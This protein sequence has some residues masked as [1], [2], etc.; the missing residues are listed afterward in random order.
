ELAAGGADVHSPRGEKDGR[1]N[2]APGESPH[3]EP[4]SELLRL[5]DGKE[6]ENRLE[7]P[8]AVL[9][10]LPRGRRPSECSERGRRKPPGDPPDLVEERAGNGADGAR[11]EE[12]GAQPDSRLDGE[13]CGERQG[14]QVWNRRRCAAESPDPAPPPP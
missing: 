2:P 12:R 9:E 14:K 5:F 8:E 4:A 3:P 6:G 1:R 7:H 11:L 13:V 10:E